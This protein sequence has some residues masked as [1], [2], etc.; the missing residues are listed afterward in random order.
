MAASKAWEAGGTLLGLEPT[1]I[2][3]G[4]PVCRPARQADA[5]K[6]GR[7][8]GRGK[9]PCHPFVA[10][11]KE[12]VTGWSTASS[13]RMAP[14][15]RL[16]SRPGSDPDRHNRF[17]NIPHAPSTPPLRLPNMSSPPMG[18]SRRTP[19]P[20]SPSARQT[21]HLDEDFYA[22]FYPDSPCRTH[23]VSTC[24]H[25]IP[26]DDIFFTLLRAQ[27]GIMTP[28]TLVESSSPAWELFPL[29]CTVDLFGTC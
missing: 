9:V 25:G 1:S 3:A 27:E 26:I 29:G 21:H 19:M 7:H 13:G 28:Q 22:T 8:P 10:S 23:I 5:G 15:G 12:A 18:V 14:S 2:R 4:L 17:R 24:M 16:T 6:S 20:A 11:M